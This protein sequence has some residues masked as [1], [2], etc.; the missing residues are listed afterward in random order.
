MRPAGSAPPDGGSRRC[1][2]VWSRTSWA[3]RVFAD[4]TPLPVLDP[5]RGRTH[6]GRLWTCTRDDRSYGSNAP[7]AV[8]FNYAQDRTGARP[9]KHL[10]T[11]RGILQVDGYAGFE[12]LAD[13]GTVTLAACWAHARREFF[14]L[15]EASSRRRPEAAAGRA[16][17][18]SP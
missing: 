1:T 5:G 13:K 17:T 15:D 9:A 18:S 8:V 14:E 12:A 16:A 2:N 4:D 10:K 6:T 7:A 3:E 11:F